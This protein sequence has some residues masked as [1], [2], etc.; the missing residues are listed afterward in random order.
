MK[1]FDLIYAMGCSFVQGCELNGLLLGHL[2]EPV[3]K[4]RFTDVLSEPNFPSFAAI[5]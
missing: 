5:K 4:N 2:P 3:V 1:R